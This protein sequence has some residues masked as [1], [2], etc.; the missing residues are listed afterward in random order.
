MGADFCWVFFSFLG[1]FLFVVGFL[2][3]FCFFFASAAFILNT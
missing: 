2:V 3:F 1:V